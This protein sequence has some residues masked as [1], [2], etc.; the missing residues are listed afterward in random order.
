MKI[1][2]TIWF[3]GMYGHVGIVLA[4]D[5]ITGERKAY[6]GVHRGQDEDSDRE[7]IASGGSKLPR[8][9]AERILKHFDKEGG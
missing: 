9:I 6:V 5:S 4:E 7:L 3:T 1:I 8:E 2:K